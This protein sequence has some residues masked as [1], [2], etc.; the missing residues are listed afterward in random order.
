MDTKQIIGAVVG[1]ILKVALAV[2]VIVFVYKGA[3]SAYDFGYRI[4]AEP[5]MTQGE[6]RDVTVEITMGKSPL[7]I[8]EIL[9]SKGLIRDARLFYVQ[10]LLSTY[11]D[12]LRPGTYVFNTSMESGEMMQ[13]MAAV[14][15]TEGEE[16]GNSEGSSEGKTGS[17]PEDIPA[18]DT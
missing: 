4:F 1:T 18:E 14:P 6:G 2:V 10:N 13:L 9:V 17:S 8:G 11:K 15:E 7:Q 16:D 12:K 5:A 3:L